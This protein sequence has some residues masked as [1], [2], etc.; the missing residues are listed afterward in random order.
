MA[1]LSSDCTWKDACSE[2]RP[3][4]RRTH[5]KDSIADQEAASVTDT[6]CPL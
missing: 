2:D 4:K 1:S 6:G 3:T 5:G